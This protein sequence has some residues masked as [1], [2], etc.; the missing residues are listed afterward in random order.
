VILD[1]AGRLTQALPSGSGTTSLAFAPDGT[2]AVGTLSGTVEL[3]NPISGKQIAAPL[4]VAAAPV[5]SIAFDPSGGRFATA[6]V[7]EGTVK[8]WYTSTLEQSGLTVDTDAH[9]TPS[10]AFARGGVALT[11]VDDAGNAFAWPM[12]VTAWGHQACA[13]AGRNL[14]RQEW[15]QLVT[16]Q[17]YT[18][19]CP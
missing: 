4:V 6:A 11:A 18:A 7:G 9:A 10:L 5:A 13:V 15:A 2:L 1:S 19:V 17:S 3:W 8:L 12:S 14:T 16:A